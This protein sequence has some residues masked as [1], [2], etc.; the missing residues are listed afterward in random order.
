VTEIELLESKVDRKLQQMEGTQFSRRAP[1]APWRMKVGER[2]L[3]AGLPAPHGDWAEIRPGEQWLPEAET[4]WFAA[5]AA[6]PEDWGGGP[7]IARIEIGC[8]AQAFVNGTMVHSVNHNGRNPGRDEILLAE[9]SEPGRRFEILLE[10]A[11]WWTDYHGPHRET[12][13]YAELVV[14]AEEGR[15]FLLWARLVLQAAFTLPGGSTER[16]RLVRLLDD[17]LVGVEMRKAGTP[18]YLAQCADASRCLQAGLPAAGPGGP[19]ALTL[20]GHAHIDTAWL[21]PLAE[22]HRKCGRTFSNMLALMAQY[23]D[24]RF[25]Q[26]QPQLYQFTKRLFPDVYEG[27]KQRVASGQW[28]PMGGAWVECDC[29]VSGGEALIRQ[30][31]YGKRF[32]RQEFGVDTEVGWWPDAFGYSWSL[33]QILAHC[34]MRYFHTTKISWNQFNTFPYGCFWWQGI[35]GTRLLAFHTVGT[36][37]GSVTPDE[38]TALWRAFP[39]RDRIENALHSFGYG[40][41]GGGPTPGM[42]ERARRLGAMPGVPKCRMGRADEFFAGLSQ[43]VAGKRISTWNGEL[44]LELHRGCQTTQSRTKRGNR[45]L[46]LALRE[47]EALSAVAMVAAGRPYPSEA[48][49]E[50]WE[51]LLCYQFHDILPGSSVNRVYVEAEADYARMLARARAITTEAVGADTAG[52]DTRGEGQPVVVLNTLSW[53]RTDPAEVTVERSGEAFHAVS[54]SGEKTPCQVVTREGESVTLLFLARVPA[55]GHAVY[56]IVSGAVEAKSAVR[57]GELALENDALRAEF[58]RGGRVVSVYD[59]QA[60]REALAPGQKGNLLQLFDDRPVNFDAWDIDPWFEDQQWEVPE[61]ESAEL[62]EAGPVRATLRFRRRTEESTFVQDVHLHAHSRRLDFVTHAD[63]HERKT[64]LKVAFPVD[65]LAPQATYEIQF[66]AIPRPTHHNTSWD[67]A[68]FEVTAHRW[69]DLSEAGYGAALLNDCKYGHDVKGNVLR[70]SLL[71]SPVDPDTEADQ[72]EHDFTYALYPHPGGWPEGEVVRR[73]L[74]LNVPLL[75][76]AAEA[77]PGDA[78]AEASAITCDRPNVIVETLKKAEDGDDLVLRLY[79]AHGARG[80]VAL[81]IALPVTSVVECNGMEEEIGP[82]DHAE[83]VLRLDIRPWQ[84]RTF[85]LRR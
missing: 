36:Y 48:L 27:I 6:A 64:L 80:P 67:R 21:W 33:P 76:V 1:I 78:P 39:E 10:A 68:K 2:Y 83:G 37:N 52:M 53:E 79:E 44:Y 4:T 19:G 13:R 81:R 49:Q 72:G 15:D 65:V 58:D 84:I 17:V 70:L 43:E 51:N 38:L 30:L 35:D 47:A 61:A 42:I 54:P 46:E 25:S 40:D 20:V 26:S 85:R 8:E 56:H 50:M 69:A 75:A 71:R 7:L 16:M 3:D 22:T 28:E 45:K 74:E 23:P 34:G 66:G 57:T 14:P 9:G 29:N 11:R 41:G 59:K 82:A 5:T 62:L 18:E 77:H 24:F 12:F 31:L 63:W 60:Q 73:G 55:C 32:Y